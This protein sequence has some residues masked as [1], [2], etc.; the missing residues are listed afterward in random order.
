MFHFQARQNGEQDLGE[1]RMRLK[2]YV[3]SSLLGL[4]I[5]SLVPA[6]V[7]A[8]DSPNSPAPALP[9]SCQ[10]GQTIYYASCWPTASGAVNKTCRYQC[11]AGQNWVVVPNSCVND[12]PLNRPYC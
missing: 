3:Q 12:R 7:T 9:R 11:L 10:L 5:V 1:A 8:Q 6:A 4:A 2:N